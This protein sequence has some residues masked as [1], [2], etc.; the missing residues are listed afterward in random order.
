[1][2]GILEEDTE[3]TDVSSHQGQRIYASTGINEKLLMRNHRDI[4]V[5][6]YFRPVSKPFSLRTVRIFLNIKL[7]KNVL[8]G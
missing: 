1:M 7:Q 5:K 6:H 3:R 2:G 8:K 4:I